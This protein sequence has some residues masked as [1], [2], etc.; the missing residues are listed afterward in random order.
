V[1]IPGYELLE[2]LGEGAAGQ[3][4]RARQ[5][6]LNRQV[7]VKVLKYDDPS[8]RA[9]FL[10]EARA[11]DGMA[12][13]SLL[14]AHPVLPESAALS[15]CLGIARAL[16]H[17]SSHGFIHR[18]VK[19]AN[20][21]LDWEG[22]ARLVDLGLVKG[23]QGSKNVGASTRQGQVL[24]T[25]H[26]IA[27][28]QIDE[29]G[30]D[31]RADLF[32]LGA[33]LYHC[34]TGKPPSE[35][36]GIWAILTERK[37][38]PIPD[39]RVT[40]PDVSRNVARL[41]SGLCAMDPAERYP[42]A[43]AAVVD[44]ARVAA[45][46]APFGPQGSAG[47][48]PEGGGSDPPPEPLRALLAGLRQTSTDSGAEAREG[49]SSLAGVPFRLT[50]SKEGEPV[51]AHTF[52]QPEVV[53]GRKGGG[54]VDLALDHPRVSRRHA[55]IIRE[56]ERFALIAYPT[57][58]GTK[59]GHEPV[60]GRVPLDPG[61]V[62]FV[63]DRF[64]VVFEPLAA[65][66]PKRETPA[67]GP[68]PSTAAVREARPETRSALPPRAPSDRLSALAGVSGPAEV[69]LKIRLEGGLLPDARVGWF[70][71]RG[72][73]LEAARDLPWGQHATV[74]VEHPI[75]DAPLSLKAIVAGS[76]PQPGGF[77][78]DLSFGGTS[79][80]ERIQIRRVQAAENSMRVLVEGRVAGFCAQKDG[81]WAVYDDTTAKVAALQEEQGRVRVCF[82]GAKPEDSIQFS[83][84]PDVERAVGMALDLERVPELVPPE[85]G[86]WG[87]GSAAGGG[88]PGD[89]SSQ[90]LR[91]H[92]VLVGPDT[93]GYLTVTSLDDAWLLHDLAW[94][95]QA[96]LQPLE[97]GGCKISPLG[98]KGGRFVH[99]V[100]SPT[101]RAG[102]AF[103]L[104]LEALPD[105]DPPIQPW[106]R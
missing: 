40:N 18:D 75:L 29:D 2:L 23:G 36:K 20:I 51:G 85:G 53:L 54:P 8:D 62:I 98:M 42:T 100:I 92:K 21:L 84:A 73:G 95:E 83:D 70:T 6:R 72:V 24:G 102:A 88:S 90:A 65:A 5:E 45:G 47:R 15:A 49:V 93:V 25:P 22:T 14:K 17:V 35:E 41:V 103:V 27:P 68:D 80:Q 34:V 66:K 39:P 59:V 56:G 32:A 16:A 97:I 4:F 33:T 46:R 12:L 3:V 69:R 87:G 7:A 104:G 37:T 19:P 81:T 13:S 78:T 91:F 61:D 1:Q 26:Y 67:A 55:S 44:I 64:E 106:A 60:E 105:L 31:V 94:Q 30:V 89:T 76:E 74:G 50:V 52:D 99:H 38:R 9:R 71:V 57:P 79:V 48:T 86:Q 10:R 43:E 28:E 77:R 63:A 82:L 11:A 96:M 101:L 58:N